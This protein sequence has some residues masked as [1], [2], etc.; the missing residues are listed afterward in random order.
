MSYTLSLTNGNLLLSLADGA[1]DSTTTSLTLVGKNYAGYGAFLN[2]NFVQLLENFASGTEPQNPL[3]GQ[4]WW[5]TTKKHL[6]VWQGANWKVISS[7]QT[8]SAPPSFPVPGDF[9][10]DTTASTFKV[11]SGSSWVAIGPFIPPGVAQTL[12][13]GNIVTDNATITHAVGNISVN[14]KLAAVV[15]TDSS[16][17]TLATPSN[18][19]TKINPGI[20]FTTITEPTMIS[21][22]NMS[23]GVSSGN[24][25]INSLTNNN[26]F[27]LTANVA[28]TITNVLSV[29]GSTGQVTVKGDPTTTLGVATKGYVD[30][31]ASSYG[32]TL[33]A[34]NLAAKTY[35]DNQISTLS[36][37][38]FATFTAANLVAKNY[39][40]SAVASLVASA[41]ATLDTLNELATALGNDANFATTMTNSLAAKAPL[42]SPALTG[43]PTAPTPA[44]TVNSTQLATTEFVR[45]IIPAGVITMWYGSVVA[46]PAGWRLCDG[47][48]GTPDLRDRFVIGAGSTYAVS[49][50]GGSKDAVVVAH[51]HSASSTSTSSVSDPGHN[52]NMYG[53]VNLGGTGIKLG[54]SDRNSVGTNNIDPSTTGISVSTSTSTTVASAG[55]SGTNA[56]LPPYYALCFIMKT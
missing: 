32:S 14:G 28:G 27:N 39:T 1:R 25:T 3:S 30:G 21:G 53:S 9:W 37:N 35:T 16:P 4:L 41:P 29:I 7:S 38:V 19:L 20:N 51:S 48:N 5:D 15:S 54:Q 50:T 11:Y 8:G 18:G 34:A 2:E 24:V 22:P 42:A 49:A 52:H 56:N 43:T 36:S 17:F 31:L 10:W 23:M 45:G 40:D 6:S 26:G 33:T 47:T 12:F 44:V 46:I 55:V 13:S